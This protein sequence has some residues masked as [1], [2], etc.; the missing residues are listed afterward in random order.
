M[1]GSGNTIVNEIDM[2]QM[3]LRTYESKIPDSG[4]HS[5]KVSLRKWIFSYKIDFM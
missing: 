1:P 3:P 4:G 5:G 2:A